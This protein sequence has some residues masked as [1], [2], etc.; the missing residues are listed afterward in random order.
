MLDSMKNEFGSVVNIVDVGN[1][2]WVW[3]WY[4]PP[5]GTQEVRMFW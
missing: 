5:G 1:W 2:D 3:N 4:E